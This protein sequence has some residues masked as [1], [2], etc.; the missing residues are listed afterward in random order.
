M[1][2]SDT[3][4]LKREGKKEDKQKRI[5]IRDKFFQLYNDHE[6]IKKTLYK[7]FA[8]PDA[9]ITT[10]TNKGFCY[11]HYNNSLQLKTPECKIYNKKGANLDIKK[12]YILK[13]L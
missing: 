11:S 6:C 2:A 12:N 9:L 1:L 5:K 13:R 7:Y 10:N 3:I 4:Q 8:E